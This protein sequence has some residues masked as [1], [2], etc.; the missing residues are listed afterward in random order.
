MGCRSWDYD[1][2]DEHSVSPFINTWLQVDGDSNNKYSGKTFIMHLVWCVMKDKDKQSRFIC[3]HVSS[4][5]LQ[6]LELPHSMTSEP[7]QH[8]VQYD[9]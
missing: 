2:W 4:D 8:T 1:Q 3:W 6:Q 5:Y 7:A 9:W